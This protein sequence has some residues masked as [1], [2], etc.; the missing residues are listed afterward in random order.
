MHLKRFMKDKPKKHRFLLH[1]LCKL[2][3]YFYSITTCHLVGKE[4]RRKRNLVED[5]LSKEN[6]LQLRLKKRHSGKGAIIMRSVSMLYC[7]SYCIIGDNA[8]SSIQLVA[9]LKKGCCLGLRIPRAGLLCVY[10]FISLCAWQIYTYSRLHR[11]TSNEKEKKCWEFSLQFSKMQEL[12]NWILRLNKETHLEWFSNNENE[13][14][15]VNF[16]NKKL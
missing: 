8:I 7:N 12:S 14:S 1:N 5:N 3:G 2:K 9:D 10:C 13:V 15:V 16:H 6:R 11:H 4:K